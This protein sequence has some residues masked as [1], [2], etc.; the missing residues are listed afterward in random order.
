L[1]R[2]IFSLF[3]II[4]LLILLPVNVKA[5]EIYD[6]SS[7]IEISD[8][9]KILMTAFE[10]LGAPYL[11]GGKALDVTVEALDSGIDCSGFVDWTFRRAVG[12]KVGQSTA[13]IIGTEIDKSELQLGDVGL[14]KPRGGEDN[15]IGIYIGNTKDGDLLWIHASS[16][17]GRVVISTC[18]NFGCF[19]TFL[20]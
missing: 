8:R 18:D 3:A 16:V 20:N 5:E 17:K 12:L 10:G 1:K 2:N 13:S 15:H 11:Y 6:N 7:G 19:Y 9:Q 4:I 14:L